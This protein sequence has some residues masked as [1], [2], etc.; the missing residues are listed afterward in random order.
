M[1]LERAQLRPVVLSA[2]FAMTLAMLRQVVGVISLPGHLH[3]AMP[4][5]S[6]RRQETAVSQ[7][8]LLSQQG[9]R[10]GVEE[11]KIPLGEREVGRDTPG[12]ATFAMA[13]DC[14]KRS[15]SWGDNDWLGIFGDAE[16][17]Q[18]KD[19]CTLNLSVL[20]LVQTLAR[21]N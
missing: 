18:I 10:A 16:K 19:C 1:L 17:P 5:L 21:L 7:R 8:F 6:V 14:L 2:A 9:M 3:S 11:A 15:L 13:F 12:E 20:S 4:F